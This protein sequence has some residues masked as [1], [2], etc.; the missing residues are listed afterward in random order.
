MGPSKAR[1]GKLWQTVAAVCAVSLECEHRGARADVSASRSPGIVVSAIVFAS[2]MT[3]QDTR[4]A[5]ALEVFGATQ[6]TAALPLYGQ[7]MAAS[8][9]C[10]APVVVLYLVFQRYLVGA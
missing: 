9:I 8:L 7:M 5:I 2:V 3:N 10:A 6:E 1:S 4:T